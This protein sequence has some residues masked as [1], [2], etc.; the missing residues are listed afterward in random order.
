MI[1]LVNHTWDSPSRKVVNI[2]FYKHIEV[3]LYFFKIQFVTII[4]QEDT[5]SILLTTMI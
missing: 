2:L 5:R 3:A 1:K 4:Q